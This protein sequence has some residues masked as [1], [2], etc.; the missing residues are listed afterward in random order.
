MFMDYLKRDI[1][2][3]CFIVA[4]VLIRYLPQVYSDIVNLNKKVLLKA[5]TVTKARHI[6]V[7]YIIIL[8]EFLVRF[9]HYPNSSSVLIFG[10][11]AFIAGVTIGLMGLFALNN[12]NSYSEEVLRY[13]GG[14]FVTHGVYSV[15]RHPMRI[16]LFIELLGMT[17]LANFPLLWLPLVAV[18]AIQ[19]FR[20][21]DEESMLK[22]YF[23]HEA[24]KYMSTVPRFNFVYGLYKILVGRKPQ[25]SEI[26]VKKF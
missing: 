20:T 5:K 14:T 13:E 21:L 26:I 10:I 15:V 25:K 9:G 3:A 6:W 24:V 22:E 8:L 12:N 18:S 11:L 4:G 17:I 16:G 2:I 19:Y 1:I 23:G 7:L